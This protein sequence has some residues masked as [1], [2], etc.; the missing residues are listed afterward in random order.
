MPM[1]RSKLV[2][3]GLSLLFFCLK[4]G[5]NLVHTSLIIGIMG[6]YIASQLYCVDHNRWQGASVQ[7]VTGVKVPFSGLSLFFLVEG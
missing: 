7:I 5:V 3:P 4:G 6:N 1:C 2:F